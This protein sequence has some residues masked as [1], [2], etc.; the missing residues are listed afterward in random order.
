MVETRWTR[1]VE[2]LLADRRCPLL[3]ARDVSW[4][5]NTCADITGLG[6]VI[7]SSN[8]TPAA[9]FGRR[10][11][12]LAFRRHTA[13]SLPEIAKAV[14]LRSHSTVHHTIQMGERAMESRGLL[15]ATLRRWMD[16]LKRRI[17]ARP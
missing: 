1:E 5:R 8:R 13:M 12:C 11:V 6:P 17:E 3:R 14:G 2:R 9:M 15:G 4:L 7:F 10:F 16:E